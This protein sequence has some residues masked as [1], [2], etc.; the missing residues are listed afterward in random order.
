MCGAYAEEDGNLRK[1]VY[2]M[3]VEAMG[4]VH[5]RN[6]RHKTAYTSVVVGDVDEELLW[7]I[8]VQNADV[9]CRVVDVDRLLDA[10]RPLV[11]DLRY[12]WLLAGPHP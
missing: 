4:D 10:E 7:E 8:E 12:L 1:Q 9:S 2:A 5:A 6:L 11:A 3:V